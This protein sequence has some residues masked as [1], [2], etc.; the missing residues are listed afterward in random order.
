MERS[1]ALVLAL[2]AVVKAGGTYVP[3]DAGYPDERLR[4]MLADSG[5]TVVLVHGRTRQRLADLAAGAEPWR[6]VCVECDRDEI[7]ACPAEAPPGAGGGEQLAY[8]MY[9]SG[10]S[11]RPK[12]VAVPQRG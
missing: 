4:F 6:L 11:G 2:L 3:L 12:G 10:S 7:A 9:T 8:V 1:A 5:V